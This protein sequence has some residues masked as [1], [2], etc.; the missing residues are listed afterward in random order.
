MKKKTKP[1]KGKMPLWQCSFGHFLYV[2]IKAIVK[3]EFVPTLFPANNI[4]CFTNKKKKKKVIIYF[5]I[6]R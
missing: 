3:Y 6:A 2:T 1:T 4:S 5:L